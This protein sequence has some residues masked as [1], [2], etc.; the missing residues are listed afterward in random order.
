MLRNSRVKRQIN[1]GNGWGHEPMVSDHERG[2]EQE[3]G[4]GFVGGCGR[5][6]GA[7]GHNRE[8]HHPKNLTLSL[9]S[10]IGSV[11]RRQKLEGGGPLAI[12]DANYLKKSPVVF[13][14]YVLRHLERL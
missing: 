5:T 7:E 12:F 8:T 4:C 13:S 1:S 14:L 10:L 6:V 2:G 9:T 3:V 11:E